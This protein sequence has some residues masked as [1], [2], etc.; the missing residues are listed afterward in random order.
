MTRILIHV[1]GQTEETFVKEVLAPHLYGV[2]FHSVSARLLG[3]A[4]VRKRRG[5]ICSWDTVVDEVARHLAHDTEAFATT[6]VDYYAMPQDWPGRTA[7]AALPFGQRSQFLSQGLSGDFAKRYPA[8]QARFIPFVAMHEFEGLLFSDPAA[9]ARSMGD[10]S[11]EAHF[12]SIRE[13]F[14]TPEHIN[15]S[16]L[17]APS[18]RLIAAMPGYQKVVHG[19]IA[20]LEVGLDRVRLECPI[21]DGWL[22]SIEQLVQ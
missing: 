22:T 7:C 2:G 1:E 6:I 16:Y 3:A 11:L 12:T 4:R 10:R 17:T 15:D 9:M 13:S 21:F 19:N 8:L 20:F 18:K 5:G 14:E